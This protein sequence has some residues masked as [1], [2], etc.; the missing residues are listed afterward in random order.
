MKCNE[1][2]HWVEQ[3]EHVL[4]H[5]AEDGHGVLLFGG[6]R[7]AVDHGLLDLRKRQMLVSVMPTQAWSRLSTC[8][9]AL[10]ATPF[11]SDIRKQVFVHRSPCRLL[12]K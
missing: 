5:V 4:Q 12:S 11:G 8:A 7:F 9:F 3:V 10:R 1:R 2:H 6:E